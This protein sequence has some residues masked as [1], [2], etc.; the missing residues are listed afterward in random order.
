M[1]D[2]LYSVRRCTLGYLG[3]EVMDPFVAYGTPRVDPAT[4]AEYLRSWEERLL[5][6][7]RDSEWRTRLSALTGIVAG[8]RAVA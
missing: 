3:L 5:A 8:N 6:T 1:R 7:A 2:V 4:R